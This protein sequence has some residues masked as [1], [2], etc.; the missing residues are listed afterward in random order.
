MNFKLT[1]FSI[2]AIAS[3]TTSSY[4]PMVVAEETFLEEVVVSAQRRDQ[5]LQDVP[6]SI[7]VFDS[8]T[9][10][11]NS[12]TGARDYIE[13]TPNVFF[14]ENDSQGTKNGDISIRG[15]S[16][17]TSG[18]NE[19]LIQTRPAVGIYV[20]DFSVGSIA[21]GSANPPLNDVERIEILKGPQGTYFGRNATGGA[22]N[23]TSV[24]PH[25]EQEAKFTLGY[26][27][28]DTYRIGG[29]ANVP[30]SDNFFAR[31]SASYDESN[32]FITNLSPTG[33]E[34]DYQNTNLRVALRWTPEN[35][36]FDLAAQSIIEDQGNQGR[37][38]AA[39]GPGTFPVLAAIGFDPDNLEATCD[40]GSKIN[41][42]NNDEYICENANT[43][44]NVENNLA[45]FKAVYDA[46]SYTVTSITGLIESEFRQFE[47]LDNT[48]LDLFNRS[49]EYDSESFSQEIRIASSGNNTFDWTA[50]GFY[51]SDEFQVNNRIITG[52]DTV[53]AF[54]GFL[55][56]P[57][58]Y[59]N[60]NNQF[61]ERDGWAVFTDVTWHLSDT[62][63]LSIGGRY[64][65]DHDKQ[66]WR[67]TYASFDCGTRQVVDG[68]PAAL[69][70]GCELRPDQAA[71][72]LP[73]YVNGDA[74]F[75][76]G[77]RLERSLF[78]DNS[79]DGT[80]FSP[81]IALNWNL[82]DDSSVFVTASQGYRP[83]GVR[84]AP[85][86]D[87]L[88][89]D[90]QLGLAVPVDTRSSFEK[91]KV[92]NLEIGLKAHFN[93]R[94][95]RVEASIFRTVWDDMQVRVGRFICRLEDGT[96]VS[97]E[98][99]ESVD[100]VGATTPDNRVQ[101][102][103]EAVSQG[104]ELSVVQLVGDSLQLS[105][106]VGFLDAE[107]TDFSNA[108]IGNDEVDVTGEQLI[109]APEFSASAAAEYTWALSNS[110]AYLRLE[111]NHR[112]DTATRLG[113]IL[114][115]DF[116]LRVEDYTVV[117]LRA[118]IEWENQRLSFSVD[119]LFEEE[120]TSGIDTFAPSAVVLPHPMF[121]NLSW[122]A[123]FGS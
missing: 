76:T 23:I 105:L 85:D 35:W 103:D 116:P 122:T 71:N 112:G 66:Y 67:N 79:T 115:S 68:V 20:D 120:Y 6:I 65:E 1:Q 107:F 55:T 37:V 63:T 96:P 49:N 108:L 72:P 114:E 70:P 97:A 14:S 43:F 99:P 102:A 21:S 110:E 31:V 61:V 95:T 3:M 119:N 51:Y 29:I 81:R 13:A 73:I 56:V 24:K 41:F 11:Q 50:G 91:E 87:L 18:S 46:A 59:P 33:S 48:G 52:I 86:S 5:S 27:N 93:D 89:S 32:G 2:A 75:V 88:G 69:V 25:S 78:T 16:D 117:N 12:W 39:G 44:S 22:I 17:L 10:E 123:W 62:L 4:A 104:L 38:P 92:T 118:G 28:Y 113:D 45:T 53:P 15:I 80:D 58:D 100:C 19:R 111:A 47:D 8:A 121:I 106:A 42:P 109:N 98:S 34:S 36:V 77:G 74:Q 57:G 54:A 83:A 30:I 94:Q 9:I 101:N 90:E 82:N 64:S 40:L 26:G 84:V 60:E 7:T